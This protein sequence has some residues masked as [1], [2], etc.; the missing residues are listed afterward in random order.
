MTPADNVIPFPAGKPKERRLSGSNEAAS[1]LRKRF[2]DGGRAQRETFVHLARHTLHLVE[3]LK[4]TFGTRSG[5]MQSAFGDLLKQKQRFVLAEDELPATLC[6]NPGNW[7]QVLRGLASALGRD[8]DHVFLDAVRGSPLMPAPHRNSF[9][10]EQWLGTFHDLMRQMVR[11]LT[12]EIDYT[13]ITTYLADCGLV[14]EAGGLQISEFRNDGAGIDEHSTYRPAALFEVPHVLGLNYRKQIEH[15]YA[16]ADDDFAVFMELS[17]LDQSLA[18]GESA[19]TL[20]GG[21]RMAIALVTDATTQSPAIALAEWNVLELYFGDNFVKERTYA[22][23]KSHVEIGHPTEEGDASI[24]NSVRF[25]LLG[26]P[27]FDEAAASHIIFPDV[28]TDSIDYDVWD[29]GGYVDEVA[30]YPTEAP[31]RTV[32]AV[33]ERNLSYAAV[34]ALDRRIDSILLAQL[35]HLQR[36]V[37]VHRSETVPLAQSARRALYE[38]WGTDPNG[39]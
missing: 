20:C 9:D 15:V 23:D 32:A 26:S 27:G 24:P 18:M 38:Q 16:T 36:L 2:R 1:Q 31:A 4:T 12:A 35:V 8:P 28:W 3:E 19:A 22:I 29:P 17:G 6:Q 34:T 7:E 39:R 25:N 33:I 30:D 11:R 13:A 14:V 37:D 10:R 21:T 5:K